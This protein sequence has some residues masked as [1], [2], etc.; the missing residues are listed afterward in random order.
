[1]STSNA[2]TN[3]ERAKKLST[4]EEGDNVNFDEFMKNIIEKIG[5]KE[6]SDE[7]IREVD[8]FNHIYDEE[9]RRLDSIASRFHCSILMDFAIQ[10]PVVMHDTVYE[11]EQLE[12]YFLTLLNDEC[13]DE[14]EEK[15]DLATG[16]KIMFD[17]STKI[18]SLSNSVDKIREI[19][20]A[21]EERTPQRERFEAVIPDEV[22]QKKLFKKTIPP[23][24]QRGWLK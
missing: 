5:M 23:S 1:M 19:A 3:A 13:L 18:Y 2:S 20:K 4:P 24:R 8:R 7:D 10:E 15:L 21:Y 6:D 17:G 12:E 16:K 22:Q 9:S 11:R 14:T